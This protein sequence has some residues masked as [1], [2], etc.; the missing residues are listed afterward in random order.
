[1][2]ARVNLIAKY[3][4]GFALLATIIFSVLMVRIDNWVGK[5]INSLSW[6]QIFV[7]EACILIA[8]GNIFT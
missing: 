1:M 8:V 2:P 6:L 3:P 7:I 5:K 4:T